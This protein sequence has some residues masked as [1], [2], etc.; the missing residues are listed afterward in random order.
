VSVPKLDRHPETKGGSQAPIRVLVVDDMV[1]SQRA[2]S[3]I[4]EDVPD[5]EVVGRASNGEEALREALRLRPSV[6][7]LDLQMPRMDGFTFLRLLMARQPT[8]VV[9]ISSNS[10]KSDVF[11]ALELGAMDFVAKPEASAPLSTIRADL[12]SKI[13]TVRALRIENLG[14]C[15]AA[16]DRTASLVAPASVFRL[17]AIG[18][19]TG[20][21][22]ALQRLIAALPGGLP[23]AVVVAQHMPE[24][25]TRTF[26]ERISKL[27]PFAVSEA[28]DGDLVVP[29]RVLVAPG[30]KHLVLEREPSGEAVR[31]RVVEPATVTVGPYCPSID[32][33]FQSV[34]ETFAERAC[35]VVLT[36]M[37]NDGRAG[38]EAVKAR[39]GLTLAESEKTAVVYGMPQEAVATGQVDEELPLEGIA[40]RLVRFGEGH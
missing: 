17:A 36:G 26:A 33:L 15:V 8:P 4:L 37:G 35:G 1:A 25:F 38:I 27:V 28:E 30:G 19:S 22:P 39:G 10:R 11:K 16:E 34:A 5:V 40:R 21:P 20:G 24:K 7:C 29:G 18:A 2:I 13:S 14:H 23:L 12:V 3:A 31:A 32:L 9:V 6:I